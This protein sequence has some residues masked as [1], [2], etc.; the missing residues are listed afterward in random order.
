MSSGWLKAGSKFTSGSP[1]WA[2]KT[3]TPRSCACWTVGRPMVGS[4]SENPCPVG[5]QAVYTL[6]AEG[7]P[8]C[9][10]LDISSSVAPSGSDVGGDDVLHQQPAGAAMGEPGRDL[11]GARAPRGRG[12]A[13]ST[14]PSWGR[15]SAWP[16]WCRWPGTGRG[17]RWP[18]RRSRAAECR[19]SPAG[20][21]L[22]R[23]GSTVSGAFCT[24]GP[25]GMT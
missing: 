23:P 22:E 18:G 19:C 20:S 13:R 11:L 25:L 8:D 17:G 1:L 5:L 16:R 10:A 12:W 24:H 9:T 14:A 3:L 6:N 4:S 7:G 15:R 2:T 21:M